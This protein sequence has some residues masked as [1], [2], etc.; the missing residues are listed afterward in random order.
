M[1]QF[2]ISCWF[3]LVGLVPSLMMSSQSWAQAASDGSIA[4]GG[5]TNSAIGARGVGALSTVGN[6]GDIT[7]SF[8]GSNS[9]SGN[10]SGNNSG[11]QYSGTNNVSNFPSEQTQTIRTTVPLTPSA[12]TT[13]GFDTCV[14]SASGGATVPGFGI[15]F[16]STK[17]D[18][19]CVM[20]KNSKRLQELGLKDAAVLLLMVANTDIRN[21]IKITNPDIYRAF[22]DKQEI[23]KR[24][25]A[26]IPT[27]SEPKP[28]AADPISKLEGHP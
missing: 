23:M 11:T 19:N 18:E 17:L 5:S 20:L 2:K 7:G 22:F 27:S 15:T 24:E 10:N 4:G 26:L 13:S 25:A 14:G 6:T 12:L 1:I 28:R 16:G 21:V 8:V 3:L 9:I